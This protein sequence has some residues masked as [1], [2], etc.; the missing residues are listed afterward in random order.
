M[1]VQEWSDKREVLS[2]ICKNCCKHGQNIIGS[3]NNDGTTC[4]ATADIENC[5]S[6]D[7]PVFYDRIKVQWRS[8]DLQDVSNMLNLRI[9]ALNIHPHNNR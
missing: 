6:I 4:S 5:R 1:R 7:R 3:L 9:R 2:M 8:E